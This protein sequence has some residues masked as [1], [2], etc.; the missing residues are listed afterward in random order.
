M[1]F[2]DIEIGTM[3]DPS[4]SIKQLF[5]DDDY[6]EEGHRPV[7]YYKQGTLSLKERGE[8]AE[9]AYKRSVIFQNKQKAKRQR[10]KKNEKNNRFSVKST[11]SNLSV[12]HKAS[13]QLAS[14]GSND[15]TISF[16]A[17]DEDLPIDENEIG[18]MPHFEK[19]LIT[20]QAP[21][22]TYGSMKSM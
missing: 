16:F 12:A 9:A 10:Q 4:V 1:Q 15:Q 6:L 22:F 18:K 5:P 14:T 17:E 20:A 2:L 13:R 3:R 21:F 7:T 8:L 11:R 19:L